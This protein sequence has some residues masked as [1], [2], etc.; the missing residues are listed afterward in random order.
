[1][2]S[3]MSGERGEFINTWFRFSSQT[4]STS[5]SSTNR[6][7]NTGKKSV[8]SKKPRSVFC[9]RIGFRYKIAP[10][11]WVNRLRFSTLP[12]T[13]RGEGVGTGVTFRT[14]G[15]QPSMFTNI[16]KHR[17]SAQPI[18][19]AY[20]R[21]KPMY[22]RNIGRAQRT[23]GHLANPSSHKPLKRKKGIVKGRT[24]QCD[25]GKHR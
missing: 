10:I 5:E 25:S 14:I 2:S 6:C 16:L 7:D 23:S 12:T 11:I 22:R 8:A 24:H 18:Y 15:C 20:R 19:R 1:M 17:F 9:A 4:V 3:V 21:R 13:P